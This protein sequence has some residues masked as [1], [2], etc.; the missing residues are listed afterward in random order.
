MSLYT[1][2]F[3]NKRTNDPPKASIMY[4]IFPQPCANGNEVVPFDW[5]GRLEGPEGE[6]VDGEDDWLW[7]PGV[8]GVS[9]L[10]FLLL[11]KLVLVLFGVCR[12]FVDDSLVVFVDESTT[13]SI[14]NS[15]PNRM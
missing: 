10:L 5:E 8:L 4:F 2:F 6:I 3:I 7:G 12:G 13:I 1:I 11:Q 14:P 15:Q 9:M